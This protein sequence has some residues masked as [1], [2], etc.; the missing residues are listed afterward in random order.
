MATITLNKDG[1][2]ETR[3]YIGTKNGKKVQKRFTASSKAQ[4]H[5][6]V[7]VAKINFAKDNPK[8]EVLTLEQAYR[9]YINARRNI[10]GTYTIHLYEKYIENSFTNLMDKDITKI[11]SEDVQAEIN[12]MASN[13]SFKTIKNKYGLFIS[14]MKKYSENRNFDVKMPQRA[15]SSLYIPEKSEIEQLLEYVKDTEYEIPIMLAALCGLRRGEIFAL[16]WN[17]VNL[18]ERFITIDKALGKVEGGY[19]VKSPKSYAGYRDVT[20]PDRLYGVL[21]KRKKSKLPLI[22]LNI[23]RMEKNFPVILKRA[24]LQKFRFHDL[25]HYFASVLVTLGIPD[26]YAIKLIGHSTTDF[27]R[28]NYQHTMTSSEEDYKHTLIENL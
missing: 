18:K 17:D 3:A 26:I 9:K 24:G 27:L 21:Q 7:M 15:K 28:K 11:T 13:S 6:K 14:V 2:Y 1:M 4:L 12:S 10:L 20:I 16:T 5:Q 8:G 23:N 22:A 25:R 19:E